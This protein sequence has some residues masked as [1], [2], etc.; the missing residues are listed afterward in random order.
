ML[1]AF[2][3]HYYLVTLFLKEI[4]NIWPKIK[5]VY[6][7]EKVLRFL[8]LCNFDF[9]KTFFY[10][11]TTDEVFIKFLKELQTSLYNNYNFKLKY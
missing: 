3:L 1:A 2:Y 4:K 9:F 10:I 5:T 7:E 11:K 8:H 6:N